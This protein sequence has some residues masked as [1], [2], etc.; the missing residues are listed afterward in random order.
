MTERLANRINRITVSPTMVVLAEAEKLR[1]RG[2]DVV[3]FGPGEPDFPTP[4]HAKEGAGEALE[5][6]R[7]KSTPTAG[8]APLRGAVCRWHAQQLGSSHE[9]GECILW[10]VAVRASGRPPRA[11]VRCPP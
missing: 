8:V 11:A 9:P 1:A 4:A 2:L 10:E 3:D 7:T 6:T 5:R